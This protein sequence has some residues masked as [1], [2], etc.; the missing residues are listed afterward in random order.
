ME[1]NAVPGLT[2]RLLARVVS[3]AAVAFERRRRISAARRLCG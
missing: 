3:A 1:Q 2:N